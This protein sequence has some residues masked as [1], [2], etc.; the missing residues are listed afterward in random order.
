MSYES[1]TKIVGLDPSNLFKR[2]IFSSFKVPL[3]FG[4]LSPVRH[5][6]DEKFSRRRRI[7]QHFPINADAGFFFGNN[8]TIHMRRLL[9]IPE[10]FLQSCFSKTT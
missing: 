2:G 8:Q 3:F 6:C 9:A 1:K 7:K 4:V 10:Y 5:L